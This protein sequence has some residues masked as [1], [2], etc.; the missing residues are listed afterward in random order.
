MNNLKDSQDKMDFDIPP[1]PQSE[2]ND[3]DIESQ[4]ESFKNENQDK[5][6][7][8]Y[9]Q[10]WMTTLRKTLEQERDMLHRKIQPLV[11]EFKGGKR[12]Y[13]RVLYGPNVESYNEKKNDKV[14]NE[15][16]QLVQAKGYGWSTTQSKEDVNDFMEGQCTRCT[17]YI[18]IS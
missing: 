6:K 11:D 2:R 15:F 13:T 3:L 17:E 18:T 12:K 9:L 14:W 10:S 8:Q 1:K 16:R 5:Y 4:L 7:D